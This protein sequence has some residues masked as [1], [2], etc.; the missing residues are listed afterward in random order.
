[1][2]LTRCRTGVPDDLPWMQDWLAMI[3]TATAAGRR[4]SRVRVVS[5]PLTDYSRFG[6]WCSRFTGDAGEDI[7][8]L[9]RDQADAAGLPDHDYWLFDSSKLVLMHFDDAD[10]FVG[11]EVIDDPEQRA[12]PPGAAAVSQQQHDAHGHRHD[13]G[14]EKLQPLDD[15]TGQRGRQPATGTGGRTRPSPAVGRRSRRRCPARATG[16]RPPTP[17]LREG[18]PAGPPS[19]RVAGSLE[20]S[21]EHAA[22][23]VDQIRDPEGGRARRVRE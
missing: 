17:A 8:Y 19:H 21:A 18:G 16:G 23:H 6:L 1:M 20:S 13:G 4:F 15:R 14:R 3:R 2:P 7:R 12:A 10:R 9:V 22:E 11:A 5:R